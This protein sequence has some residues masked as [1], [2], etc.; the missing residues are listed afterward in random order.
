MFTVCNK[1]NNTELQYSLSTKHR[2]RATASRSTTK[3]RSQPF[4]GANNEDTAPSARWKTAVDIR[5][6]KKKKSKNWLP[7]TEMANPP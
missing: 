6:M 4:G 1:T 5:R 3:R 7:H 2:S